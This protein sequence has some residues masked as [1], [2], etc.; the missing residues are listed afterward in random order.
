VKFGHI[1]DIQ[2]VSF[3]LATYSKEDLAFLFSLSKTSGN[4]IPF[5]FGSTS[6][7]NAYWK[8]SIYPQSAPV[9]SF[10]KEYGAQFNSIEL[11]TT[12]YRIPDK[13]LVEKWKLAM[14]DDFRF[15]PKFPQTVS[16]R[17][18]F[19]QSSGQLVKFLEA[20]DF[21]NSSLGLP[22]F[23]FPT[24]Y[25]ISDYSKVE[26]IVHSVAPYLPLA[27]E[28][29][30][31]GFYAEPLQN[32][33]IN[34][35]RAFGVTLVQTD[36]PGVRSIVHNFITSDKV[37]VRFVAT[38]HPQVDNLR[39]DAW[40]E[41]LSMLAAHGL[42]EIYFYLHEPEAYLKADMGLYLWSKL[43]GDSTFIA[44]GPIIE[45]TPIQTKLF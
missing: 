8:G 20:L 4:P 16:H 26:E 39:I 14:P 7:N 22:F 12:H 6:W 29:R 24:H 38:G 21:F 30:D 27:I 45:N 31:S 36:T 44:R 25:K 1:N 40:L 5:Y 17:K 43:N 32:K 35:L 28:L 2:S 37:F 42:K 34:L 19:G 33:L 9:K 10:I 13:Q 23:Q 11:N 15:S 3:D 41:R 18:D